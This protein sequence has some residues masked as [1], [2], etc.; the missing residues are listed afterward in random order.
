MPQLRRFK[1]YTGPSFRRAQIIRLGR[2]LDM[3]YKPSE[4]ADEIDI[5]VSAI[6]QSYLPNGC[7]HRRDKNNHI[8]IH[9][10]SFAGWVKEIVER[11]KKVPGFPLGEDEAWCVKCCKVVTMLDPHERKIKTNL[12]MIYGKCSVCSGKVN[13]LKSGKVN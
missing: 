5:D 6:Y 10:T 12:N 13:R 8:W 2:L 1:P 7:P 3:E 9:G 4:I 11:N